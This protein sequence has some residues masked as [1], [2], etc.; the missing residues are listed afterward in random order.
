MKRDALRFRDRA[1]V[2]S[3]LDYI[4]EADEAIPWNEVLSVFSIEQD[5]PRP[6]KTVEN[7]LYELVQFGALHRVGRAGTKTKADTRALKPTPLG[8]AWR[9]RVLLPLP[10]EREDPI[11]EA[12]RVAHELEA[13]TNRLE[14]DV[15]STIGTPPQP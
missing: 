5:P 10:G 3:I 13:D 14:L 15:A 1:L 6:V 4:Y 12:D 7:A 9:D 2:L 11:E 8:E